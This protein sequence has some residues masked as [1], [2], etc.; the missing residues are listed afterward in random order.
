MFCFIV[1]CIYSLSFIAIRLVL[2][3]CICHHFFFVFVKL[4]SSS[5]FASFEPNVSSFFFCYLRTCSSNKPILDC[6]GF[7]FNTPWFEQW[8]SIIDRI[9]RFKMSRIGCT[10]KC[11]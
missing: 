1:K 2:L 9:I 10:I 5:F 4:P 6:D 11:L 7:I 8:L 3:F